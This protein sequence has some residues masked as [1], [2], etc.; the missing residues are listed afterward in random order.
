MLG[1]IILI[2]ALCLPQFPNALPNSRTYISTCHTFSMDVSFRLYFAKWLHLLD[3]FPGT[4]GATGGT[5]IILLY[6]VPFI[7]VATMSDN[8]L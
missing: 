1:E 6:L 3:L 5:G 7:G 4:K 2:P 8:G